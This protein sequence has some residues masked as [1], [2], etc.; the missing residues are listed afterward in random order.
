MYTLD[1]GKNKLML[2]NAFIKNYDLSS[3]L[4]SDTEGLIGFYGNTTSLSWEHSFNRLGFSLGYERIAREYAKEFKISNSYEDNVGIITG[5]VNVT[6]KTRVFIEY[7]LGRY[8]YTKALTSEENYDYSMLWVGANG[9][10]TKKI[11]GLAKIGFQNYEYFNGISKDGMLTVQANLEYR[12][13]LRNTFLLNL[14]VGDTSTGYVDYGMDRQYS[15]ELNFIR[16]LNRKLLFK[17]ALLYIKDD[18]DSG[19][20]DNTFGYSL[21]LEYLLRKQIKMKLGYEYRD[22]SST[23]HNS[24]YKYNRY[25]FGA[26]LAF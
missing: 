25:L 9:R 16:E 4:V 21:N 13:S 5:F 6:P 3:D 2:S 7:N 24:E 17:G 22:R 11:F 18:Y 15:A 8:E 26:E 23:N 10:L 19:Q 20:V 1:G 12:Q 14:S